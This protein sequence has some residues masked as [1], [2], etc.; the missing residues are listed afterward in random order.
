[1]RFR[2]Y[3]R[4]GE[5][6]AEWVG[7]VQ[8]TD[9]VFRVIAKPNLYRRQLHFENPKPGFPNNR[10][11]KGGTITPFGFRSGDLVSA[12]KAGS[13]VTGWIGGFSESSKVV[14][15]YDLNWKRLGQYKVNKV[16]L[17]QRSNKLCVNR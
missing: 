7:Q 9:S 15:V 12:E 2:K 13:V 5:D 14:G 16:K 6:G 1:M 4:A 10:K 17:I 8:V 11:R 3:H